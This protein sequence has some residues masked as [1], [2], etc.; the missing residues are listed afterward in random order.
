MTTLLKTVTV[1]LVMCAVTACPPAGP[2]TA[3]VCDQN[4]RVDQ[5]TKVGDCTRIPGGNLFGDRITCVSATNNCSVDDRK[6]LVDTLTCAEKLPVCVEA[7][8]EA[9]VGARTG[10]VMRLSGISDTCRSAFQGVL[11]DPSG[12]FDGG[13]PDAGPQ[14]ANDGGAG[15]ELVVVADESSF[16]FAWTT[17]QGT[18]NVTRWA[19]IGTN[20]GGVRDQPLFLT[21]VQR[22]D[23]VL[24]DAGLNTYRRFFLLG[25]SATQEVA[26]GSPD[27]GSG[28]VTVD[29]G[30][31]R[32]RSQ[33]DCPVDR[34]CDLNQCR[35]QTC[36]PG[37]SAT[38]PGGYQCTPGGSCLRTAFDGGTVFDAGAMV[39]T[40][41]T[42]PLPLISNE[43]ALLTRVPGFSP[44]TYLGGFPGR[45]P[46]LVAVDS[47]RQFVALEQEGQLIG[48]ASSRRGRDFFDDALTASP[49]DTVGTRPRLAY[50]PDSKVVFAC[51]TVGRG[52]RVQAST[53]F[54][55]TW[56]ELAFT[57]ERNP[58]EDGG[59][60]DLI[61]D[62]DIAAWKNGGALMVTVDNDTLVVRTVSPGLAVEDP[63]ALA[64]SSGTADSGVPYNPAR[65]SIATLPSESQVHIVFTATRTLASSGLT[66]A[67]TYG[68]YRD[69]TVP[70]FT[71]ALQLTFTGVGQGNPLPDD[72]ATVAIDPKTRRAIAAYTTLQPGAGGNGQISTVQVA[73]FNAAQRRWVTGSDLSVFATDIDN[74]TRL[75]FPGTVNTDVWDAFSPSLTTLPNGKIWLS[76]V[77][78]P[79]LG[80]GSDFKMWAVPFDFERPT[81]A[82][83]VRGW[84]VP[85]GRK[86][87]ET[88]VFD[89]RGG[90]LRPPVTAFSA[91]SQISV[92]G[93]FTEGFG[94]FGDQE[95]GRAI[96]VSLP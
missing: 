73:L 96:F 39:M 77:A 84:F 36:T 3:S 41:T 8:K 55:R 21:P 88:R 71:G 93:V 59:V 67:E 78:G 63:G 90:G 1:V 48:H 61:S 7:S 60:S 22:R 47:A 27:S 38:C 13:I 2:T 37:G 40:Q 76:L 24:E 79:R 86:V 82:G 66:D 87:S 16:A 89:P 9:W 12:I 74:R 6:K 42:I 18:T 4:D 56:G 80:A 15:L 65:P 34:V 83:N 14:P 92:Y 17:L 68:V 32:C 72:H 54:G 69:G 70:S 5:A 43:V 81:P 35:V 28:A 45:R 19:I 58:S 91:D 33:T 49:L 20:D 23:F 64:F 95:G 57:L 46:D 29:G 10:C 50:N 94:E 62:C 44:Q 11:P 75:I 30:T 85:P 25:E 26:F 52:V 53:D 51:Y 31:G